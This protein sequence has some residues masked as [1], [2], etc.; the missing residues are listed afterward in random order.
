[1]F[2]AGTAESRGQHAMTEQQ[3]KR[4]GATWRGRLKDHDPRYQS[5]WNFIRGSRLTPQRAEEQ[6]REGEAPPNA[7][8]T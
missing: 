4:G 5:G 7:P 8:D 6:P 2:A 1:V 3:T